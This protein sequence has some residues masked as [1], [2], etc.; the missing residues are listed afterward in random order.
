MVFSEAESDFVELTRLNSPTIQLIPKG[1]V[2]L[3]ARVWGALL[4]KAVVT[5]TRCD[6]FS[7]LAFP[8]CVLVSPPVVVVEWLGV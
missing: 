4:H 8:R 1:A 5:G 2:G 7:A 6:W 3:F